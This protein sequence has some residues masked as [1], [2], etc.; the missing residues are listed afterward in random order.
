[1]ARRTTIGDVAKLAGVGKVTVSYVLNGRARERGIST[2]TTERIVAAAKSLNYTPNPV[3]RMLARQ[4]TNTFAIVFQSASYFAS[5]SSFIPEVLRGVC[6]ESVNQGYDVVLH[7]K[8]TEDVL[9]DALYLTSGRVDGVLVLRD[10]G[11]PLITAI[12]ERG[13][14]QVLFF[15]RCDDPRVGFVDSDNFSG[16]RLAAQ[17]LTQLGH[18]R[19]GMVCGSPKSVDAADRRFGFQ[20]G[21]MQAGLPVEEN[22]FITMFN[23]LDNT[24]GF[25]ELMRRPDRPTAL[26]VWS[27]DVAFRC[28]SLLNE[29]GLRVPDD[30]SVIGFDST[31]A[32]ERIVPP[33]TSIRQP[34]GHISRAAT[35][36]LVQLMHGQEPDARH[37]V[38]PPSL[39]LRSTTAPPGRIPSQ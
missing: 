29:L 21:L 20:S 26:F 35:R 24:E 4:C 3:G 39:D 34:I 14:P 18:R 22:R 28:I 36:L 12:A 31:E 2:G 23:S 9:A 25:R 32:C 37:L 8:P 5:T 19:I 33:L 27:D 17:H 7:T 10:A 1:M 15:S 11:D 6:E 16:G 30:V 38:F 13:F